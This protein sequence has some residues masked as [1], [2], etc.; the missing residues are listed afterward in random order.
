MGALDVLAWSGREEKLVGMIMRRRREEGQPD[1]TL[2]FF[3][4]KQVLQELGVERL[5]RK[6]RREIKIAVAKNRERAAR[7]IALPAL[8][9]DELME[10]VKVELGRLRAG[11]PPF[12]C[13]R[14]FSDTRLR[15]RRV[16]EMGVCQGAVL[17]A[18]ETGEPYC[19]CVHGGGVANAYGYPAETEAVVAVGFS[20][21]VCVYACRR[22][23]ANKVTDAGAADAAWGGAARHVWDRRVKED[24]KA[25]MR[26]ALVLEAQGIAEPMRLAWKLF[27]WKKQ[28]QEKE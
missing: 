13:R 11:E 27:N 7:N 28:R 9:R 1:R 22:T 25:E 26:R 2:A 20:D 10:A 18:Q 19:S 24:L 4:P 21:G 15:T 12:V 16:D 17:R 8:D 14:G 6:F 23:S 5:P 3:L